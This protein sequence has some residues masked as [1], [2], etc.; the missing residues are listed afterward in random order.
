MRIVVDT[1]VFVSALLTERGMC[2]SV[3]ALIPAGICELCVDAR[4]VS[5]Y[6]QVFSRGGLGA[7]S[8][9]VALMLDS[10]H[11]HATWIAAKPLSR[12]LPDPSDMPFLE[13]AASAGA[14]IVTGN[15]RHFPS[16]ACGEVAVLTP[17]ELVRVLGRKP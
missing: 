16:E 11:A 13:V 15:L 17:A 3:E 7:P 5:E 8:E 1:N 14:A 12:V 4:I 10:V 2:A 6:E 9:R